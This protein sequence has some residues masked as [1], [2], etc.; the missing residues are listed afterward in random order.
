MAN[1]CIA[2]DEEDIV[3][4]VRRFAEYEGHQVWTASNGFE[5][6]AVCCNNDIDVAI[7]DIMMPEKDGFKA[8]KEIRERKDIPVIILSALGQEYDKL[9]GFELGIDDYVVKPFS[10]KELLARVNVVVKRHQK[11][12]SKPQREIRLNGI[13]IDTLGRSVFIDGRQTE[14]TAK[15]YELLLYLVKNRGI[16]L[17]REQILNEIWGY[18][19]LGEDRTVDWQI[20]LL[21]NKLGKY[22]SNIVTLRG[23]GYKF[24]D[25]A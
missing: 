8:C 18:D 23:M 17:S 4:L 7:L 6:V 19:Y 15:E 13:V 16:A 2:D 5:A 3:Q 1:I 14:L 10:P 20:K 12:E 24:E 11:Q 21:R 9:M 22:R 25:Q